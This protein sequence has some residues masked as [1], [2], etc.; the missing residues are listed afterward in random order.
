MEG[1]SGADVSRGQAGAQGVHVEE[2][3]FSM[4][5]AGDWGA[6]QALV[7][8]VA[9]SWQVHIGLFVRNLNALESKS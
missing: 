7:S 2:G 8:L 1:V 9:D 3:V 4:L 6:V 5:D